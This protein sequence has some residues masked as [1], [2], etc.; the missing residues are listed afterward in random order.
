MTRITVV[1]REVEKLNPEYSLEFDIP[2]IPKPGSYI[3]IHRP[4]EPEPYGEDMIVEKVWWR[5]EHPLD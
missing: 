5:L 4:D 2:E 3:S 1:N